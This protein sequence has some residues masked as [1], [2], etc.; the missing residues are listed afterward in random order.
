MIYDLPS[1]VT[2]GGKEWEINT[3]YRDVLNILTAFDDPE[4]TNE[5]KAY[6]CLYNLYVD[7]ENI[8]SNLIQQAYDAAIE[9]ID[10]GHPEEKKQNTKPASTA[11]MPPH[12]PHRI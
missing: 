4:L 8:P 10:H 2:F 12:Q 1:S 6:I 11:W 3:D 7:Y 5:E 9:F